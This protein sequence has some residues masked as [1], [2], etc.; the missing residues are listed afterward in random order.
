[1][2]KVSG[3][4]AI[5]KAFDSF[6]PGWRAAWGALLLLAAANFA[7]QVWAAAIGVGSAGASPTASDLAAHVGL[8]L[9]LIPLL[10]LVVAASVMATTALYRIA[11]GQT[12]ELGP[13]GLQWR[14]DEWRVLGATILMGLAMAPI[15]AIWGGAIV[16]VTVQASAGH[17]KGAAAA[18]VGWMMLSL[19][20]FVPVFIWISVRLSPFLAASVDQKRIVLFAAWPMTG[21][22][23]WSIFGAG[24]VVSLAAGLVAIMG[25][26]LAL[27]IKAAEGGIVHQTPLQAMLPALVQALA[28]VALV[29]TKVGLMGHIYKT[30][31]PSQAHI[32]EIFS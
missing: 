18:A 21:G 19:L 3:S 24:F 29:P 7:L 26:I 28:A 2:A 13:A 27:A 4:V 8:F 22:S 10:V 5:N 15:V 6:R 14:A 12:A 25:Q 30:I 23:F 11:L 20:V 16:Y 31:R 32:A 17:D 1:M 9:L